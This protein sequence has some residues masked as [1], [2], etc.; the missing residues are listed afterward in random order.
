MVGYEGYRAVRTGNTT[1]DFGSTR[2]CMTWHIDSVYTQ[3]SSMPVER[4]GIAGNKKPRKILTLRGFSDLFD[5]NGTKPEQQL[6][7]G[8]DSNE[9]FNYLICSGQY[10]PANL[11]SHFCLRVFVSLNAALSTNCLQTFSADGE[12]FIRLAL[13]PVLR[14]KNFGFHQTFVSGAFGARTHRR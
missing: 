13:P 9:I 12:H 7:P 1:S 5:L 8:E 10:T 3:K 14:R 11:S 2:L 4:T 6:V